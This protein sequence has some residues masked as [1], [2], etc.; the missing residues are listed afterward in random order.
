MTGKVDGVVCD[1]SYCGDCDDK[2]IWTYTLIPDG[3][4]GRIYH[5]D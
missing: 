3:M 2:E 4:R 1:V 5:H